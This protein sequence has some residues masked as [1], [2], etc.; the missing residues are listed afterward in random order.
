[1]TLVAIN[2]DDGFWCLSIQLPSAEA[3]AEAVETNDTVDMADAHAQVKGGKAL[4]RMSGKGIVSVR[5]KM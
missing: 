5:I 3:T 4:V 1:M 2:M